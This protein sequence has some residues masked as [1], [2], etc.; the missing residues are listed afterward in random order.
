MAIVKKQYVDKLE[1]LI[2][3]QL[4]IREV[5]QI[6]EDGVELSK[7]YHRRVLA[8]GADVSNEEG[9]I[10]EAMAVAEKYKVVVEDSEDE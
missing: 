3:G 9:K 10:K 2:S 1:I 7:S 8:P 4:Q 5:T 6:L